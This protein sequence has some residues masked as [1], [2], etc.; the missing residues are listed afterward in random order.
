MESGHRTSKTKIEIGTTGNAGPGNPERNALVE[1]IDGI[2]GS[3]SI[4][5]VQKELTNRGAMAEVPP[6]TY[7]YMRRDEFYSGS[8]G[9]NLLNEWVPYEL[10]GMIYTDEVGRCMSAGT[11]ICQ[12][13]WGGLEEIG[14]CR[15]NMRYTRVSCLRMDHGGSFR[16]YK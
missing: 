10:R 9:D 4:G 2:V 15:W 1:A 5:D 16:S 14:A 7:G 11:F 8:L 3:N 6:P 13:P 12:L